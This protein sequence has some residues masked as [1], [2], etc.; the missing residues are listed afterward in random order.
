MALDADPDARDLLAGIDPDV[1]PTA[2][3]VAIEELLRF[4]APAK[5]MMRTVAEAHDHDGRPFEEGQT[6]FMNILAANRDPRM[7]DA[8][9]R[10]VLDR[11]PNP[12][13]TFGHGHHFCLGAALARLEL[14]L[15]LSAL[16]RRLPD[17]HVAAPPTWKPN[18][19]DRSPAHIP[20]RW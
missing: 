8:P 12:H 14:R 20:V 13:L 9:D 1:D 19:S 15:A 10:L 2:L 16:L 6:V 5:A 7:F 18:I 3:D 11:S 17:L 4:V